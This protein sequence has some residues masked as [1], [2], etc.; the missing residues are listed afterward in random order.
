MGRSSAK[1]ETCHM[2]VVPSQNVH[3]QVDTALPVLPLLSWARL[4]PTRC[5]NTCA[6]V[7]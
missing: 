4:R 5:P 2:H 1:M 6:L 3:Q 7:V